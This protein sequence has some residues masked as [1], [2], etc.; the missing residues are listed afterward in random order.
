MYQSD[1]T[2]AA[3]RLDMKKKYKFKINT[4]IKTI[5]FRLLL[6][7]FAVFLIFSMFSL[8][9]RLSEEKQKRSEINKKITEITGDIDRAIELLSGD[10]NKL[11]EWALREK[12]Y[13]FADEIRYEH[14]N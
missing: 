14:V 2:R 11:I 7:V 9:A 8:Q 4:N 5:A 6:F 13:V 12:D 3:E 1:R 10:T